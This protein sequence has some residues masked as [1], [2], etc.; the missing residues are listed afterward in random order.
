MTPAE[1]FEAWGAQGALIITEDDKPWGEF[2]VVA[3]IDHPNGYIAVRPGYDNPYGSSNCA[4]LIEG[5]RE[6][7]DTAMRY[8]DD[9]REQFLYPLDEA[10]PPWLQN[11]H[12]GWLEMVAAKGMTPAQ[13]RERLREELADA[14]Q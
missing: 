7:I 14:F 6:D 8:V 12:Q 10:D 1:Q 11:P 5:R 2:A 3:V 13:E 4:H 9:R